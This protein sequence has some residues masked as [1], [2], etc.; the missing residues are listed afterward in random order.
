[1][2][3]RH[4]SG[5]PLPEVLDNKEQ[6]YGERYA[7]PRGFWLSDENSD[8]SWKKWCDSECFRE[9]QFGFWTDFQVDM[10]DIIHLKNENDILLFTETYKMGPDDTYGIDWHTIAQNHKGILITPYIWECRLNDNCSWYYGWDCASGCFWDVSCLTP[11]K[12]GKSRAKR[13]GH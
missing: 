1:M 9:N 8:M 4:W 5:R 2:I 12:K 6:K 3:L 10:N 7:K 13:K 11:I